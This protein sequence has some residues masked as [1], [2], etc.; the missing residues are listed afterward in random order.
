[1]AALTSRHADGEYVAEVMEAVGITPIRGSNNHGGT[2]AA[3][4]L[5]T[6]TQKHH[7]TITTDGPRGPRRVVKPGVVFLAS[8]TGQRIIPVGC[9]AKRAWLP[10]GRWT[11]LIVPKPFTTAYVVGEVPL[12]VPPNL[13]KEQLAPYV[14][15]LQRRMDSAQTLADDLATGRKS[16]KDIR[17]TEEAPHYSSRAA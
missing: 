11:D 9:S 4:Q 8:Q 1:M 12:A 10:K 3:K 13:T 2:T 7:I 14:T 16:L 5:M 17:Q 15:E 6:A